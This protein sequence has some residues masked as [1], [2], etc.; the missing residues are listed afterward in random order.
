MAEALDDDVASAEENTRVTKY[1]QN[2]VHRF[3]NC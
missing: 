3:G 2:F 1:D